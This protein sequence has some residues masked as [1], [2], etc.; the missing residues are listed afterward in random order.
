MDEN[1]PEN[2]LT[3]FPTGEEWS[4]QA[5][6]ARINLDIKFPAKYE[7][8]SLPLPKSEVQQPPT[9]QVTKKKKGLKLV[10]YTDRGP[11]DNYVTSG[12]SKPIRMERQL[13][14]D[15]LFNSISDDK[16]TC[17]LNNTFTEE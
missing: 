15:K 5:R 11:L 7:V 17:Q 4:M 13:A 14:E 2:V 6:P 16:I 10:Q 3:Y 1:H 12:T 9:R 8:A